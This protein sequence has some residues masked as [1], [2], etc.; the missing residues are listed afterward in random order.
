[1]RATCD[2]NVMAR[3]AV[4]PTGPARAVLMELLSEQHALVLSEHMLTE[5]ARVLRYERVRIQSQLT[6]VDIDSFVNDVRDP[7]TFGS[8]H[9]LITYLPRYAADGQTE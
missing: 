8:Q 9:P 3:A 5:L 1:M 7:A 6:D 4:R 2:T